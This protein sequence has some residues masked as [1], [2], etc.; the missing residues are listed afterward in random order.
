[1]K[2]VQRT[3][4]AFFPATSAGKLLSV[5]LMFGSVRLTSTGAS[6]PLPNRPI[7]SL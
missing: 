7:D 3:P 2:P 1:M 4:T 5:R 6:G